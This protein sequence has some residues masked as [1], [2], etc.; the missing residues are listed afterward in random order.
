[1]TLCQ[2][3]AAYL[4]E[5]EDT[6]RRELLSEAWAERVRK[7]VKLGIAPAADPGPRRKAVPAKWPAPVSILH[8]LLD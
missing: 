1:M 4:R 5:L 7:Q 6:D 3:R 8:L 2:T